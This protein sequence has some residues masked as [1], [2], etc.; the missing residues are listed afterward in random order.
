MGLL[1]TSSIVPYRVI[2]VLLGAVNAALV[3]MIGTR[4]YSVRTGIIAGLLMAVFPVAS[5]FDVLAMQD[6]MALTLLLA[7]LY[8]I[9]DR[10]F[11]SGLAL[12]LA[13]Q[14]RT[15]YLAASF[16]ILTGY[17]LRER[18]STE[19]LPYVLGW[20]LGM[21]VFS[22]HLFTQT[23]NP[24]YHLY[25]SLFN[26]FGGFDPGNQGKSF[27]S[28]AVEWIAWKLS[29][30]PT[31]P[32]GLLI[33]LAGAT[34][35]ILVPLMAWK[36]WFRYQPQLYFVAVTA[37]QL[38][39]FIT[40]LG[41]DH[42]LLLIMLRMATP[43]AALGYPILVHA[44][45]MVFVK[46]MYEHVRIRP[47]HILL[48]AS[49]LSFLYIVPVYQEFQVYA[50]DAFLSGDIVAAE[51][52]G[53]VIVCD[54]PTINY[55]LVNTGAVDVSNLLGNHYSPAFYGINEPSEFLAWMRDRQVSIWLRYDYR[56]DQVWAVMEA[57]YPGVL[58]WVTD[59]PCARVYS[60]DQALVSELLGHGNT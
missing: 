53:G 48:A 41:S 15:E 23:G 2:N 57:N 42:V 59:T 13:G 21:S 51:Y 60:V 35:V 9:R 39:I 55:R 38:P 16:I 8:M 34:V 5:V 28:L 56:S 14:S 47:E 10:P 12:A 52:S 54:H 43:I 20:V 46:K 44:S 24:F 29:V 3:Q 27:T 7:S 18:L 40:Y 19:S 37:F 26:V 1:N 11:W 32:T 30:W 49:I 45:N 4:S 17:C 50:T 58:V 33:L 6:T 36:R 22:F 25:V 31:K